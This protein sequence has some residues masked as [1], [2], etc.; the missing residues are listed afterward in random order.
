MR[1]VGPERFPL[2]DIFHRMVERRGPAFHGS[3]VAVHI[4]SSG[5]STL[6][7]GYPP[8]D[9]M[10]LQRDLKAKIELARQVGATDFLQRPLLLVVERES[11]W[12]QVVSS[13]DVARRLGFERVVFLFANPSASTPRPPPSRYDEQIK[14]ALSGQAEDRRVVARRLVQDA[15]HRCQALKDAYR[16]YVGVAP[17][18]F[19]Q[20]V[21]AAP[22]AVED[23][24]CAVDF[25]ALEAAHWLLF[26]DL[27]PVTSVELSLL[28]GNQ[29]PTGVGLPGD[30]S[31]SEAHVPLLEAIDIAAPSGV[32]LSVAP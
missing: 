1:G 17:E 18:I 25:E 22:P 21:D 26:A 11:P 32:R 12:R 23:C 8:A 24:S 6:H 27:T 19:E 2:G 14:Q 28:P 5:I 31:W 16:F 3:Y 10:A 4:T 15:A 7:S 20:V 29:P 13:V 30:M 9:D